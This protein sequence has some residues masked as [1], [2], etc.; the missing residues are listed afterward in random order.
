MK[1]I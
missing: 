1:V